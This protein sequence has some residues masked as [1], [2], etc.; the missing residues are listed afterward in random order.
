MQMLFVLFP[1]DICRLKASKEKE[2]AEPEPEKKEEEEEEEEPEKV[3]AERVDSPFSN[4]PPSKKKRDD[5][6]E[7]DRHDRYDE[8]DR[9]DRDCD[10]HDRS[11]RPRSM[12]SRGREFVRGRGSSRSRGRGGSTRG[13]GARGS[14][15]R[16]Y[17]NT[18]ERA[19]DRRRQD[20]Q[21]LLKHFG[22]LEDSDGQ[23]E[24]DQ[25]RIRDRPIANASGDRGERENFGTEDNREPRNMK[26]REQR[27]ER[28][29]PLLPNAPI[30]KDNGPKEASKVWGRDMKPDS[31]PPPIQNAWVRESKPLLPNPVIDWKT[32]TCSKD[33]SLMS[34]SNVWQQ[35]SNIQSESN[36]DKSNFDSRDID[37]TDKE[38]R[39]DNRRDDRDNRRRQE[40]RG[41]RRDRDDIA[42]DKDGV[43][44][45]PD[46]R[47]RDRDRN[48]ERN[49]DRDIVVDPD[50]QGNGS[51]TPRGEPSRRGRGKSL[52]PF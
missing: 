34:K 27:R 1:F 33:D 36:I 2:K 6:F 32:D 22:K 25:S 9:R 13:Y 40:P 42:S 44:E 52:V 41:G 26:D 47:D 43:K 49:R 16:D 4:R 46:R 39:P 3:Y 29:E 45:R 21:P 11:D 37:S 15:N 10:R 38:K 12:A 18:Y 20:R 14:K 19:Q 5:D 7:R 48:R 35:R 17:Y 24:D 30:E 50:D 51:F 28:R 31:A 23:E 8:H